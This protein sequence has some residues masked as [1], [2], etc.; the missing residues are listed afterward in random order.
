MQFRALGLN[1][2]FSNNLGDAMGISSAL[3]RKD[4]T[5]IAVQG[6]RRGGYSIDSMLDYLNDFLGAKHVQSSIVVGCGNLGRALLQHEE[7]QHEGISL[8]AGFD[9]NPQADHIGSV[10]IYPMN[11]LESFIHENDVK[12]AILTVPASAAAETRDRL[13]LAG[14]LGIL[15]FAPMD[16]HHP[17]NAI[18]H[19]VNIGLEIESLFFKVNAL[20]VQDT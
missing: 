6:N 19:N 16:L 18:I 5:R 17:D 14:I 20:K 1:R 13:L 7:F 12:V 9:L 4:M 15:N 8:I 10:K 3:V 11:D 2:V